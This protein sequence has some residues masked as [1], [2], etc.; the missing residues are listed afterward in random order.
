MGLAS[1]LQLND[2]ALSHSTVV[3]VGTVVIMVDVEGSFGWQ[4][5]IKNESLS[6]GKTLCAKKTAVNSR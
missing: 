2:I 5:Q 6:T 3:F 4:N 1:A